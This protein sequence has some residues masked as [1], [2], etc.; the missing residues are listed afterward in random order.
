M[1]KTIGVLL[2]LI[3]SI[4]LLAGCVEV[5]VEEENEIAKFESY[6]QMIELFK[7]SQNNQ[8]RG[9]ILDM[10]SRP[11]MTTAM[12]DSVAVGSQKS[13]D[14]SE[15]NVQ[16]KGVDEADIVKTDGEFIY[17][18]ASGK[19]TITK[20][21]PIENSELISI[22]QLEDFYPSEMFILEDKLLVFGRIQESYDYYEKDIVIDCYDCYWGGNFVARLYNMEDKNNLDL[23]KE[24]EQEG[25]YVS[26]RLIDDVAYFMVNTYPNYGIL[27]SE[28]KDENKEKTIIPRIRVDGVES[29]L[30]DATE[31]GYMPEVAPSNFVTIY[32]LN[33][34]N[35]KLKK[36]VFAASGQNIY[37]SL[38]NLYIASTA[39]EP[40]DI[41]DIDTND[42]IEQATR[43]IVGIIAP[44][45]F[46]G[47]EKTVISKFA[48]DD[49]DIKYVATGKV[50]GHILNQFSMDEHKNH[51]R[52]ATT[53]GRLSRNNSQTINALYVLD[54]DMIVTGSIEDIAPGESIYSARFMGD[55]GYIVTF[56][57]VD[58]FFA[59]DLSDTKNPK[60][61]GKL[62]IPGYSDY[63]HPISETHIL[64][65]GKDTI[66]AEKG[67]FAWYQGIK[68][69]IFDVTDMTNP[70]ELHKTIIGDRG[71][72]S[73]ALHDHKA[74]LFDSE[75]EILVL[76]INLAEINEEDKEND[77]YG[78]DWP[79]YGEQ[80]FSGAFVF[81]ISAENGITERGRITHV[82]QEEE[83]KRGY[84]Y[85]WASAVK[86][87]LYIDDILYTI[88]DKKILANNLD[89]LNLVKEFNL[90][91]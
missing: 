21:Y 9:G 10:V 44:L 25:N 88:S 17:T 55:K 58:P 52:I 53:A 49:G 12:V 54:E 72:D 83:L 24:I 41:N 46:T 33:L 91:E 19:L 81:D 51:F 62:K 59:I 14:F 78:W 1:K 13:N 79:Q 89:D 76:P 70:V 71:T 36:E 43:P 18:I 20:A 8:Y 28:V 50:P 82:S 69:A 48:I 84:Y 65:L 32:S 57:K 15:T 38:D 34:E 39:Y 63:L 85:G 35:E 16:V 26:S 87:S 4:F 31:I 7:N 77:E 86:R 5:P 80:T 66:A 74:F 60:I 30:A 68:M 61:L 29:K 64:G 73:Y 45:F 6:D 42:V 75:K 23:L 22:T 27:Y 3:I 37:S 40:I 2:V 47:E 56:K 11:M 67:D 90:A